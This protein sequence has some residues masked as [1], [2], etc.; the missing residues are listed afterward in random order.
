MP[1]WLKH[2]HRWLGLI[3][4]TQLLLWLLSGLVMAML[5]QAEV[6]GSARF[7]LDPATDIFSGNRPPE[8]APLLRQFPASR[9]RLVA[10]GGRPLAEVTTAS[11]RLLV[12]PDTGAII[13]LGP[14]DIAA[15]AQKRWL[16]TGSLQP[17]IEEA[18]RRLENR[19]YAL[20][21]WRVDFTSATEDSLY[22]DG[23]TGQVLGAS[24]TWSRLFDV[25]W[26]L[27]IMD[28][29]TR[30][31]FNH[32]LLVSAA[33]LA[34][35]LAFSGSWLLLPVIGRLG[36]RLVTKNQVKIRVLA[37]GK[38]VRELTARPTTNLLELLLRYGYPLPSKCGGGGS[39]GHC[40]LTLGNE[41]A[42]SNADQLWLSRSALAQGERL[43]CQHLITTD[44]ALCLPNTVIAERISA[45][46]LAR[47]FLSPTLFLL[48][49]Q[50]TSPLPFEPGDYVMV[51]CPTFLQAW[52]N[53]DIPSRYAAYWQTQGWFSHV[54]HSSMPITRAYSI[55]NAADTPLALQLLVRL[56]LPAHS[57]V[58]AGC[59]SSYLAG[60]PIGT[61]LS[62]SGPFGDFHLRDG[63]R[64]LLLVAGGAGLAPIRSM[65]H[66][67]RRVR[68]DT[69]PIAFW[70]GAR[71]QQDCVL[72][73]ELASFSHDPTFECH[74]V[75]SD[76]PRDSTWT[77]LRGWVHEAL[78][79]SY[80]ETQ[81]RAMDIYLCGPP[82]MITA[83]QTVL[84]RA[85]VM[86]ERV[87]ID[88][89]N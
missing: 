6:N 7:N 3:V 33:A 42:I 31:D 87:A 74:I 18:Q 29:S 80:D 21:V 51:H 11:Q 65:L 22:L 41:A 38:P 20:P 73:D 78:S 77:G 14:V 4:G 81:L 49:L 85:N 9:L 10:I 39:C 86:P 2:A 30:S 19:E 71:T 56:V 55:A 40:R 82:A 58:S 44:L 13:T 28:Y 1:I 64:P 76:E 52:S 59:G 89:F 66:E 63:E 36:R 43:A 70:Y 5:P 12:E 83:V 79:R 23:V 26:M 68:R 62:L 69:R 72:R 48:R 67:L 84:L 35:L 25:F 61:R 46:V 8:I 27:H 50:L 45:T 47:E 37:D 17:P 34:V 75:L 32:P 57:G 54:A 24:N 60:V 88:A 53:I 16:G 15:M